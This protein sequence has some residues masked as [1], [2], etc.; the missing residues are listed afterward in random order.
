MLSEPATNTVTTCGTC[1]WFQRCSFLFHPDAELTECDWEPSRY[2]PAPI[3]TQG[4]AP[5]PE[6]DLG[7]LEGEVVSEI[8]DW[9][10][11]LADPLKK[12]SSRLAKN[13]Q[14][15]ASIIWHAAR[16]A[17]AVFVSFERGYRMSSEETSHE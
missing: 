4:D 12:H 8:Y 14:P 2:S 5:A 1:A 9:L 11:A 16:A 13:I 10:E 6:A 17:A 3:A 7:A 15:P